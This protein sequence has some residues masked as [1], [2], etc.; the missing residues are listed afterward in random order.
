MTTQ[1]LEDG[2]PPP[3]PGLFAN[4]HDPIPRGT[5]LLGKYTV[6][7]T[8]GKGGMGIVVAARHNELG[9]LRA[10]KFLLPGSV[11]DCQTVERFKR[12]AR[13]VAGLES[14]HVARVHD[15]GEMPET[16]DP[17]IVMEYLDGRDFKSI[18][19]SRPLQIAEAVTYLLQICEALAEAHAAGVVHRDLKPA[20]LMLITRA[21]RAPCVKVLDFGIAKAVGPDEVTD[22]TVDRGFLGTIPYM[23]PE[24]LKDSKSVDARTDI[25][26]LGVIAY[27]F[28]AAKRPFGGNA[29]SEVIMAVTNANPEPPSLLNIHIPPALEAVILKC[30]RKDRNERYQSV[31]E[32]TTALREVMRSQPDPASTNAAIACQMPTPELVQPAVSIHTLGESGHDGPTNVNAANT[33]RQQQSPSRRKLWM[34]GGATA[35]ALATGLFLSNQW[36]RSPEQETAQ[37]ASIPST[38]TSAMT[39]TLPD[40]TTT[41]TTATTAEPAP[42]ETVPA[43]IPAVGKPNVNPTERAPGNKAPRVVAPASST[44]I[45]AS[46]STTPI[47]EEKT[48]VRESDTPSRAAEK[49]ASPNGTTFVPP[50]NPE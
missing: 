14:M 28:V 5:E 42:A 19:R 34:G 4:P 39:P 41:T 18:L 17:Y 45:T 29:A 24:H 47:K 12:E 50:Q 3:T 2:L 10:I 33:I 22:L 26:A 1:R 30:L 25:W 20:N 21:H 43:A 16:G 49:P 37:A 31:D 46:I 15:A 6:E 44:E 35:T 11:G 38:M 32:L 40:T 9:R 48:V 27:E 7:R 23:S 13:I 36:M 8:L